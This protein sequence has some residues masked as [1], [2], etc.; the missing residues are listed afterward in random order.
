MLQSLNNSHIVRFC[1]L[2]LKQFPTFLEMVLS[3]TSKINQWFLYMASKFHLCIYTCSWILCD[4]PTVSNCF[5]S[6]LHL[7]ISISLHFIAQLIIKCTHTR[8]CICAC[9]PLM[10]AHIRTHKRTHTRAHTHTLSSVWWGVWTAP[11]D[12]A[13][14]P[15][16]SG[17]PVVP[18][19]I[20]VNAT[21]WCATWTS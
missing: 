13:S 7:L 2:H 9:R 15:L 8:T 3:T 4:R 20:A 14:L 19:P 10:H 16:C 17:V 5:C 6:I 21:I 11:T 18:S 1:N 12:C